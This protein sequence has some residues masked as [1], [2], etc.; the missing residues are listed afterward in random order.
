M[1]LLPLIACAALGLAACGSEPDPVVAVQVVDFQGSTLGAVPVKAEQREL[2]GNG[3]TSD[4]VDTIETET[5]RSGI[6]YLEVEPTKDYRVEVELELPAD[7]GC[8]YVGSSW[9]SSANP[10]VTITLD[11][12]V[13][14]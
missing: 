9:V 10:A 12:K 6:A 8:S 4:V 7:P 2:S 13:C 5:D 1:K 3:R 14:T 11:R